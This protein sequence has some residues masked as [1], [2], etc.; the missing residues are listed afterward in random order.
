M[1]AYLIAAVAGYAVGSV[2][3]AHLV[4]RRRSG[5]DLHAAGSENVGA[6]NA[7]RVTGSRGVGVLVLLLDALK[8]G[9]AVLLGWW[10]ALEFRMDDQFHGDRVVWVMGAVALLSAVAGHN[11]NAVLSLRAG[12]LVGGKGLATGAGG[13]ALL[14]PGALLA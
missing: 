7:F 2:P 10:L 3:F 14:A 9:G 1:T 6:N 4:V 5:L 12:R 11:Y 8:G 13:F